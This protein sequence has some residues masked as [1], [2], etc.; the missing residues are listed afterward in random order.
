[1]AR[2]FISYKRVDKLYK[3]IEIIEIKD[4]GYKLIAS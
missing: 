1:M 2:I 4:V 3:S